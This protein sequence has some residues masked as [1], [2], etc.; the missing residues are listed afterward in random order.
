MAT[1][2]R[3]P[4]EFSERSLGAASAAVERLETALAALDGY[5]EA[6]A[7]DPDL[8]AILTTA[9]SA[10]G[11]ALA[12]DLNVSAALGATFDLVREANARVAARTFSTADAARAA[13]A[14]RELDTVLGVIEPPREELSPEQANLLAERAAARAARDWARSDEL[15]ARLVEVGVAVE[16]TPD[17]QRWRRSSRA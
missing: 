8:P 6:R 12:D 13:A 17:G 7:D 14:L 1:H 3:S 9:R 11:V 15:R 16:D 5:A 4:I 2:Y 10:F